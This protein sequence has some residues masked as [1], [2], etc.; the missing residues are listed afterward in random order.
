MYLENISWDTAPFGDYTIAISS[1]CD[2]DEDPVY[3]SYGYDTIEE[4]DSGGF[5]TKSISYSLFV[6]IDGE[7]TVLNRTTMPTL[8][9]YDVVSL[10][11][12]SASEHVINEI[13]P[14]KRHFYNG[15]DSYEDYY[16]NYGPYG[17]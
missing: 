1:G 2:T 15:A 9:T 8:S 10:T 14:S 7:T 3:G 16:S 13:L 6:W 11:F 17:K 4:N 12:D 5:P